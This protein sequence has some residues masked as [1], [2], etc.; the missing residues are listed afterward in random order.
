MFQDQVLVGATARD[1]NG[2]GDGEQGQWRKLVRGAEARHP[3]A[4]PSG[5]RDAPAL[6][7]IEP[8]TLDG[9]TPALLNW[10]ASNPVLGQ[11]LAVA[12]FGMEVVELPPTEDGDDFR[13]YSGEGDY[14]N[15][16]QYVAPDHLVKATVRAP[17]R[18]VCRAMGAYYIRWDYEDA[19]MMCTLADDKFGRGP[20]NGT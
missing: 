17:D 1:G 13:Y 19:K 16:G 9:V 10:E 12:G 11:A 15:R 6:F 7:R 20:C 3:D 8:V 4:D 14:L 2:T 5:L 18:D